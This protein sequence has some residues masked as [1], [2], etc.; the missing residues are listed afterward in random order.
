MWYGNTSCLIGF[1]DPDCV[2]FRLD[3]EFE[4]IMILKTHIGVFMID[5]CVM[6]MLANG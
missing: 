2:I 4:V 3:L 6:V 1:I 5:E